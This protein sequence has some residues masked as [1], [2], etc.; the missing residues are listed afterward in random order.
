MVWHEGVCGLVLHG[1]AAIAVL[2]A[3]SSTLTARWVAAVVGNK[4]SLQLTAQHHCRVLSGAGARMLC[5][6]VLP[7][8][9]P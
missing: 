4:P 3:P 7:H 8:A 6:K 2:P 9:F 1:V 5:R